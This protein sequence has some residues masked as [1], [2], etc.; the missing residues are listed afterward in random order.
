MRKRINKM[1]RRFK[2]HMEKTWMNKVVA[3]VLIAL[4]ILA[5]IVADGDATGL[6]G[7]LMF[8]IPMIFSKENCFAN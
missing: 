7:I 3:L 4:G 1:V 8:A 6:F 2:R 5:T